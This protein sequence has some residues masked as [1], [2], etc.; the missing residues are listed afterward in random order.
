[1]SFLLKMIWIEF[2][3]KNSTCLLVLFFV[4]KKLEFFYLI[5]SL[6]TTCVYGFLFNFSQ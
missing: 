1:M 6:S 5:K 3:N 4:Y 2:K